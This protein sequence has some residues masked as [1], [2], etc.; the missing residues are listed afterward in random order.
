MSMYSTFGHTKGEK[1]VPLFSPA[2]LRSCKQIRDESISILYG[3]N[4]F[5]FRTSCEAHVFF[6]STPNALRH[7]RFIEVEPVSQPKFE[8]KRLLVTLKGASKLRRLTLG[9]GSERPNGPGRGMNY[10]QPEVAAKVIGPLVRH[11]WEQRKPIDKKKVLRIVRWLPP[12]HRRHMSSSKSCKQ[13]VRFGAEV[14][15]LLGK[16]LK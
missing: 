7:L 4:I 10:Y 1:I 6:E 9:F 16:T 14:K 12:S 15:V 2:L 8:I 5:V 11:F 13:A 3:D